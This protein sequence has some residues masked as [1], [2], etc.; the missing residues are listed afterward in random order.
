MHIHTD[1]ITKAVDEFFS[2]HELQFHAV[3]HG[4]KACPWPPHGTDTHYVVTIERNDGRLEFDYW[5]GV[6]YKQAPEPPCQY[7]VLAC[8]AGDIDAADFIEDVCRPYQIDHLHILGWADRLRGFF[9]EEER[10]GL[11]EI[12]S[13]Y[14]HAPRFT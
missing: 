3:F 1:A 10:E 5:V 7:C 8:I 9:T 13:L 6:Y 14:C 11:R 12:R 2:C 4:T